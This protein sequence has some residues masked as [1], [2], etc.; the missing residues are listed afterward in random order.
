VH[1]S[2]THGI[3]RRLNHLSPSGPMIRTISLLFLANIACWGAITIAVSDGQGQPGDALAI[4]ITLTADTPV[5]AIQLELVVDPE[6]GDVG[7][8]SPGGA[9]ADHAVLSSA[10]LTRSLVYSANSANLA[11]GTVISIPFTVAPTGLGSAVISIQN[12]FLVA[13]DGSTLTADS[14]LDGTLTVDFADTDNDGLHDGREQR[15]A[16]LDPNDGIVTIADVRP[17]DDSDRDGWSLSQEF[18]ADT[19]PLDGDSYPNWQMSLGPLTIGYDSSPST[20][21]AVA[22]PSF[23]ILDDLVAAIRPR[24]YTHQW[25]ICATAPGQLSWN[26]AEV[27]VNHSLSMAR[28]AGSD[29]AERLLTPHIDMAIESSIDL[30][31]GECVRVDFSRAFVGFEFVAGWNLVSLP[32]EPDNP[33]PSSI[34]E[35]EQSIM[36]EYVNEPI[37]P[38]YVM[39]RL[40]QAKSGY[41]AY[42]ELPA[43]ISVTGVRPADP[44]TGLRPGWNLV[45]YLDSAV[46][47]AETDA[48]WWD[49]TQQILLAHDP[50]APTVPGRGYWVW[51]REP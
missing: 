34:F 35:G 23:V 17:G 37:R 15:L 14:V 18:A 41:W 1:V 4:A 40:M 30:V 19:D 44:A 6:Q 13:P 36:W 38:R 7:V 2:N 21:P 3:V 9:L 31:A 8:A 51:E 20:T 42:F 32:L 49:E 28:I 27:P 22:S 11:N 26:P 39:P 10:P 43:A 47:P 12:L 50:D 48:F 24:G 5:T 25:I 45:G 33:A 16:N 29:P 46:L